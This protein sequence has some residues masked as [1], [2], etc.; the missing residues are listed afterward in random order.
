MK[1]N[2]LFFFFIIPY[3][4]FSQVFTEK[5]GKVMVEAEQFYSQEKDLTRKWYI[6]DKQSALLYKGVDTVQCAFAGENVFIAVLPDTRTTHDDKL[7]HEENFSNEP[8]KMAIVNYKIH[9]S[10]TGKYYVWVKAYSTG[11]EDNGIH[12]GLDGEWPES[13]QRMQWCEGKGQWS[14]ASK[15][16]TEANHCGEG[17]LIFLNITSPGD[18]IISFSMREDGFRFDKF[19]LNK[20]WEIPE[21]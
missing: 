8:G 14:W 5:N 17:K 2:C 20:T 18:H 15:Q 12:V 13:G 10:D 7:I 19:S 4:T 11:T 16:R 9:F 21:D 6:I 3:L 1:I